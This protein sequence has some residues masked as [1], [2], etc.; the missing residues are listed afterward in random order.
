MKDRYFI[1]QKLGSDVYEIVTMKVD[2]KNQI[3]DQIPTSYRSV[4]YDSKEALIQG[5]GILD[6]PCKKCGAPVSTKWAE[7][8]K[9][10]IIEAN[11]CHSCMFWEKKLLVK[12]NPETARIDHVHY[13]IAPDN[14][15]ASFIGYGGRQFVIEFFDGRN[16]RTKNLWC[17][18]EIP[19]RYR[20]ELPDNAK[21]IQT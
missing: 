1:I 6:L 2:D 3:Q 17:N 9:H 18:G 14:P 20:N 12:D 10:E 11:L 16:V 4:G 15:K 19:K 13:H 5:E 21:F 8:V 7:P